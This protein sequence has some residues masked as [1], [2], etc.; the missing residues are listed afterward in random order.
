MLTNAR[1]TRYSRRVRPVLKVSTVMHKR[2]EKITKP[3]SRRVRSG[4]ISAQNRTQVECTD[5]YYQAVAERSRVLAPPLPASCAQLHPSRS[6][7]I[8]PFAMS[9]IAPFNLSGCGAA[10]GAPHAPGSPLHCIAITTRRENRTRP[11][12][13]RTGWGRSKTQTGLPP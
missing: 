2:N 9:Q 7:L 8:A 3:Y 1:K 6:P 4:R 11:R 5:N 12:M 10:A 13:D